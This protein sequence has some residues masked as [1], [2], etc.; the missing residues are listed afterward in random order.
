MF[1]K[2]KLRKSLLLNGLARDKLRREALLLLVRGR[3]IGMQFIDLIESSQ[4]LFLLALPVAPY[5]IG[6]KPFC[7][8]QA[9]FEVIVLLSEIH[10]LR[11][12]L[13]P[14]LRRMRLRIRDGRQF[15]RQSLILDL[16]T[17]IARTKTLKFTRLGSGGR[18][19]RII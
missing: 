9:S 5:G 11:L 19:F 15:S 1:E 18:I 7:N 10:T 13:P 12:K 17:L 2:C 14:G 3:Q 6:S 4:S 8:R 16:Q